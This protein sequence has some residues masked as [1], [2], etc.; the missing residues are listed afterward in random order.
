MTAHQSGNWRRKLAHQLA[1]LP[2]PTPTAIR[3][4]RAAAH[5]TREEAADL[6]GVAYRTF[7]DWEVGTATMPRAAWELLHVKIELLPLRR[8]D[9]ESD[10]PD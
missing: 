7:Q 9:A 6:V 10:D 2:A 3:E 8:A 4:K 5:I 1:A